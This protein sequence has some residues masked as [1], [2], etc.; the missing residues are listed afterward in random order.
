MEIL[1]QVITKV[2]NANPELGQILVNN[3]DIAYLGCIAPD[4][5]FLAP[6]I[7]EQQRD[8]M[9]WLLDLYDDVIKPIV[10]FYED[11]IEP[12]QEGLEAVVEP[13]DDI[14]CNAL[15]SLSEDTEDLVSRA[16]DAIF[17][18][19]TNLAA[20]AINFFELFTPPIQEGKLENEWFW[21]DMLHY[22]S[23]SDYVLTLIGKLPGPNQPMNT[24]EK[25]LSYALGHLSHIAA[26]VTGHAFVNQIVGGPYRSHNRR[27]HIMEN[28]MDVWTYNKY[29]S[30]ELI[31][32]KLHRKFTKGDTLDTLGTLRAVADGILD[33]PVRLRDLFKLLETSFVDTYQHQPH[34]TRLANEFLTDE[35][36]GMAYWLNL[37]MLKMSTDCLLPPIEA[38]TDDLLDEINRQW[39]ELKDAVGDFPEPPDSPDLCWAFWRDDCNFSWDAVKEFFDFVWESIKFLGKCLVWALN[40]LKELLET[41]ACALIHTALLPVKAAVW[42]I[43][44]LLTEM[45]NSFRDALVVAGI[46]LP[47]RDYVSSSPLGKQFTETKGF[48]ESFEL[49]PHRQLQ[50]SLVGGLLLPD[51]THLEY[52]TSPSEFPLT[53]NGPYEEGEL[54]DSFIENKPMDLQILQDFANAASPAETRNI[55]HI[56]LQNRRAIGN[57]ID[58]S[59]KLILEAYDMWKVNATISIPNWNLDA[60]RGYGYKCWTMS[61]PDSVSPK[62]TDAVDE[63]YISKK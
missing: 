53:M 15:T 27:H 32:A 58:Y 35:D 26:D 37:A 42:L 49:Y 33:P 13:I 45:Y 54:P 56:A 60:D 9:Y 57:A 16:Q 51:D 22:R 18:F 21:F 55:E 3:R 41:L 1:D 38:P 52:P 5:Y 11:Y 8:A 23:T 19:L 2:A 62:S 4:I 24:Y 12:V 7:S 46:A 14:L 40:V 43:R 29:K 61:N 59:V 6:D 28:F 63:E 20:N 44:S 25:G 30:Q 36:I 10:E 50:S 34:P 48:V 47:T 17:A 39:D 31:G